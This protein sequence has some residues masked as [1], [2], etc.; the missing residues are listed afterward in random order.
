MKLAVP[1]LNGQLFPH[2]GRSSE[3]AF[4]QFDATTG[5]L[6]SKEILAAPPHEPGILPAWLQSHRIRVLIAGGIGAQAAELCRRNAIQ[7]LAGAPSEPVE[8]I[9]TDWLQGRLELHANVCKRDE[10]HEH[11]QCGEHHHV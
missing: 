11:R 4:F 6:V 5:N 2:F 10:H 7:V 8:R 1:V 9:V 3:F